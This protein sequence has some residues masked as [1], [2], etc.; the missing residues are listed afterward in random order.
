MSSILG[1][2]DCILGSV[3]VEGRVWRGELLGAAGGVRDGR[4]KCRKQ[5][6]FQIDVSWSGFGL[7]LIQC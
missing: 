4:E 5:Q 3:V 7:E 1:C 6:F 2:G